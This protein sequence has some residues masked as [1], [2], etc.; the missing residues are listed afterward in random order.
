MRSGLY[1]ATNPLYYIVI[2]STLVWVCALAAVP[3]VNA[4][5]LVA[6]YYLVVLANWAVLPVAMAF[7]IGI[8]RQR[9]GFSAPVSILF[10]VFS[11]IPVVAVF[12]GGGYVLYRAR[13]VAP[14]E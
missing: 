14:S 2:V 6:E 7:D 4:A 13:V 9:F 8:V 11:A 5:G 10:I 3:L 12:G 1:E